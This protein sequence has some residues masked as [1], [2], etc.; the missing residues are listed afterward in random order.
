[1]HHKISDTAALPMVWNDD[2]GIWEIDA[3]QLRGP[4]A[5]AEMIGDQVPGCPCHDAPEAVDSGIEHDEVW[6]RA[7][8]VPFPDAEAAARMLGAA[9][10]QPGPNKN[11]GKG[12]RPISDRLVHMIE[13]V[14]DD[15]VGDSLGAAAR[16]EMVRGLAPLFAS[17]DQNAHLRG[18]A[19][20]RAGVRS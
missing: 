13:G 5:P 3:D 2:E 18:V 11:I 6:G 4:L 9:V 15:V 20:G 12:H 1:M 17:V 7:T 19:E 10:T 8:A 16:G 14:F